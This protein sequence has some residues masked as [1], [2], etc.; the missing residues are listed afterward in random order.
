[1]KKILVVLTNQ[2][3]YGNTSEKIG[4]WLSEA[5]EFVQEVSKA[6]YEVDYISPKGGMVPIDPRSLEE[7]FF[8][9]EAKALYEDE[10][11]KDRAL[12]NSLKPTEIRPEEYIA[13]YYAGGHGVMWDFPDNKELQQVAETIYHNQGF[14]TSVCHGAVGL[15]NLKDQFGEPL[16]KGKKIT[17][18]TNSEE[19]LSGKKKLVP[20]LTETALKDKGAKFKQRIPYVSYAVTDGQFVTGQNPM[21]GKA[22]EVALLEQLN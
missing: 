1:M 18:F 17:G 2:E 16:I 11:F 10:T 21:S 14:V 7:Q 5:T 4:L 13:I 19:L 22:V 6:G 3:T 12:T 9:D 15:M 8:N 20:F